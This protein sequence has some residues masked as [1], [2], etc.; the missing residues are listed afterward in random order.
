MIENKLKITDWN[1]IAKAEERVSKKKALSLYQEDAFLTLDTVTGLIEIHKLLFEDIYDFAGEIRTVD[2]SKGGFCF[3]SAL[4]LEETLKRIE[5]MPQS[6]FENIVEKYVEM[7]IAHPFRD[8]NG[9]CMRIWL[10]A[11]LKKQLH[12]VVDW[13]KITKEEYFDAMKRSPVNDTEIKALL[14]NAL[15]DQVN[16]I[17]VFM[18]G[19]DASYSY[20]GY[21]FYNTKALN[22]EE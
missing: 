7:N 12:R 3:G 8:G 15:T 11:I 6:N 21:S 10:D 22:D 14:K 1:L 5:D 2:L 19:L 20:E 17:N 13:S 16:D 18:E 9:R 4:F